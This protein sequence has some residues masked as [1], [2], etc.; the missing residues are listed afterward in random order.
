MTAR[1]RGSISIFLILVLVPLYTG[2]YL[3]VGAVRYSAGRSRLLG[4]LN[5]NGNSAL[6]RY[7]LTLKQNFD[8][9]AMGDP[10]DE[11]QSHLEE[12]YRKMILPENGTMQ[13]VVTMKPVGYAAAYPDSSCFPRPSNMEAV[14]GDYMEKRAPILFSKELAKKWAGLS[15]Q[16]KVSAGRREELSFLPLEESVV[17]VSEGEAIES[18]LPSLK[19]ENKSHPRLET[20]H[21]VNTLIGVAAASKID[22]MGD[23]TG[24]GSVGSED[25]EQLEKKGK[26]LLNS[27]G[28]AAGLPLEI[29]E[30]STHFFSCYTTGSEEKS[31]KDKAY[32]DRTLYRAEQEYLLYG[33]D[34]V[35]QDLRAAEAELLA[36]RY[37]L[38]AVYAFSS[39]KL[40]GEVM[41]AVGPIAE[42]TG[43]GAAAIGETVLA[44]WVL[45]ESRE[46]VRILFQGETVPVYKTDATWRTGLDGSKRSVPSASLDWSYK[47]YVSL[48][49]LRQASVPSGRRKLL[50]RMA[51]LM[52]AAGNERE[53][54]FDLTSCY[55]A[56][57][58]KA[59][60]SVMGHPVSREEEYAY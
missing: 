27:F 2:I 31:L 58:L 36:I 25:P 56:V 7:D 40:Q 39:P 49:L 13:N 11:L 1:I 29:M 57:T 15:K 6:N 47:D 19:E 26:G 45:M 41:S 48:L 35:N 14:L 38:N 12:Q 17:P 9:F 3:G 43:L 16:K 32:R 18:Y 34:S 46:D 23:G 51:K 42:A 21:S 60:A 59:E 20:D 24:S 52:Q 10:K 28:D 55:L 22:A 53:A 50:T 5:L 8:L 30:Y 54:S 4:V 37:A 33:L 44:L